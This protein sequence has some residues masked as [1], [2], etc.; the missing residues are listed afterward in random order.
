[1]STIAS[2]FVNTINHNLGN[3]TYLD[4]IDKYKKRDEITGVENHDEFTTKVIF[5]DGSIAVI[6]VNY[7]DVKIFTAKE[8]VSFKAKPFVKVE[9]DGI[10]AYSNGCQELFIKFPNS[11]KT[12][13]ISCSSRGEINLSGAGELKSYDGFQ[14]K[15]N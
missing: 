10:T 5:A 15:F 12:L 14:V 1:M 2:S 7:S 13:R 8:A 3:N 11:D 4:L 9:L 6:D